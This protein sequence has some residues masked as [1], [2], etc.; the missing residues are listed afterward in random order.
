GLDHR[1]L[2]R[3]LEE[4]ARMAHEVL[5]DRL[6]ARDEDD[7]RI[8]RPATGTTRALEEARDGARIAD[9][10]ADVETADVDAELERVRADE[11]EEISREQPALDLAALG[12]K[13]AGAVRLEA[14]G[15][16][17]RR[18]VPLQPI[19]CVAEDE[20]DGR[21]RAGEADRPHAAAQEL[22][23]KTGRDGHRPFAALRAVRPAKERR[24]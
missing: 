18:C 16:R 7:Q 19:P 11:A 9:E 12:R 24:V 15:E 10:E 8:L 5:I 1:A 4:G 21:A 6:G 20:L 23:K 2:G 3:A 17:S 14:I 22:G 13:I